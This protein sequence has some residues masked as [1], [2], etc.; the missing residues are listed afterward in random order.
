LAP[1]GDGQEAESLQGLQEAVPNGVEQEAVQGAFSQTKR[2]EPQVDLLHQHKHYIT[3]AVQEQAAAQ[4]LSEGSDN[5]QLTRLMEQFGLEDA[6]VLASN[7]IKKDRDLSLI[8][9]D[10]I[11][12][13]QLSK[14]LIRMIRRKLTGA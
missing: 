5:L 6:D 13:L 3:C 14:E 2:V 12:D 1:F 11:R 9:D 7:G 8:D 10:V 4:V